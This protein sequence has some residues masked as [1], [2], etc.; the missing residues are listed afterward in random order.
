MQNRDGTPKSRFREEYTGV[1]RILSRDLMSTREIRLISFRLGC[2]CMRTNMVGGG[3]S[4]EESKCARS[5]GLLSFSVSP[6]PGH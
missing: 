5:L 3:D 2:S 4:V 1:G 6:L